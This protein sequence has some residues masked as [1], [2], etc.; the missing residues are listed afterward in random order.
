MQAIVP[1]LS[2]QFCYSGIPCF[3]I[4]Q[5]MINQLF[6]LQKINEVKSYLDD[7]IDNYIFLNY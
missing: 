5:L 2:K 1:T 4:L 7:L 3:T 6:V